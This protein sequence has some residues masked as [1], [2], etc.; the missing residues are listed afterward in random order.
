MEC[1]ENVNKIV[2]FIKDCEHQYEKCKGTEEYCNNQIT[3]CYK[4]LVDAFNNNVPDDYD[5][6]EHK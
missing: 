5:L 6:E 3:E 4:P 2:D 1:A